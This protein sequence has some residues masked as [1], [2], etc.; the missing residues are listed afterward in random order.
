MNTE[1]FEVNKKYVNRFTRGLVFLAGDTVAL[2]LSTVFAFIILAPFSVTE[3][4]FPIAY[5]LLFTGAVIAGMMAFRMYLV[6]WRYVSL[7]EM[8]RI[9][10]GVGVGAIMA[11]LMGN[12]VFDIANFE[13]A[14]TALAALI[15]VQFIGGFRISKRLLMELM[16]SPRKQMKHTI[17]YGAESEG[18]QILRDIL[19]SKQMKMSVHGLFDD[20]A[21]PGTLMQETKILG[22]KEKM[23]EYLRLNPVEVM[24][25]AYPEMPKRE[26]K[27]MI[28]HVKSLRPGIEIKILPSFH[29]LSDDPVGVQHIRDISI[30]DILGREPVSIDMDLIS[31]SITGRTVM[32]TGAGGSIGSELVRQCA[33]L[34]PGTLVALDV[35]ETEL[36]HVENELRK[37][38]TEIVP[39]VASVTDYRKMDLIM[40][41]V[42]PDV[43]FHAAAYKHVPM[44]ESFP[45]E[46]IKV[47]V[48]GTKTLA[49]LACRHMVK[50][51]VMI[52]TD[53]AVN[54]TNVM[55]ASKRAAEEVCMS[56][57]DSCGTK[58]IS[59]RFGNVLGSRGSV[60]PIFMEQIKNGGPVCV[61]H[62]DMKRYFMTIPEAVLLVMQAGS[63]GDGGEVFV[64]D[65][66][67]PVKITDM[68]RDLI[69]L[70]GLE[71]DK[72]IQIVYSGLRPGEKL[73]EELLNA[74]EGVSDTEHAEVF[75][76]V[77][78]RNMTKEELNYYI[79][80]IFNM[81]DAGQTEHLR[82]GL[83][84]IVPTYTYKSEL[85][86]LGL[87]NNS[88]QE[89]V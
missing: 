41:S 10:N 28:D 89:A 14:F 17:I 21:I 60:V 45:E 88:H 16:L 70:H 84:R 85:N 33:K 47:N 31:D 7:R 87:V 82:E 39:C 9:V 86:G 22:G 13:F 62:P 68:A 64:L 23:Y 83:K 29:S 25:V 43:I 46:A 27:E 15:A 80:E 76:A 65:M 73:F 24:I 20:R 49:E 11:L 55:G 44:M 66:G 79:A 36:F 81:I 40:A 74:E 37:T 59:V 63:M 19:R 61:T 26:L 52:S 35:D 18:D 48:G 32:V 30:E 1:L 3:R 42:Q 54:P 67:Q 4:V 69:R 72:D 57:N 58:F 6:T 50:K 53:K 77:C 56:Y 51:F 71:P 38:G 2:L 5:A 12:L 75:K 8:V 78:S 34:N